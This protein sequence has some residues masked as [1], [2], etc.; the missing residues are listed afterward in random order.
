MT[1]ERRHAEYFLALAEEARPL[2]DGRE[3]G[4]WLQRM[5]PELANFRAALRWAQD[6]GEAAMSLRFTRALLP[7]WREQG[8]LRE[9]LEWARIA[10][11][12]SEDAGPEILLPCVLPH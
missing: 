4:Q 6:A 8:Y 11:E 5:N 3:R 12:V 9:G 1:I 10:L 7:Y 2:L